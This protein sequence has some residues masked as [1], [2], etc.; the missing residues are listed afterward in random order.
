MALFYFLKGF[1]LFLFCFLLCRAT[2]VAYGNSQARGQNGAT[3]AS[4]SHNN[5]RFEMHLQ[6]TPQLMAMLDPLTH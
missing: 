6:P 1:F 3:A 2:L 5:A 4:H